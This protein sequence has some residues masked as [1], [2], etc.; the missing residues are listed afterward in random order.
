[1][2][3]DVNGQ[4]LRDGEVRAEIGRVFSAGPE[5]GSC[6]V[7]GNWGLPVLEI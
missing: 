4:K 2:V 7:A 1:M 5:C 6:N 3:K